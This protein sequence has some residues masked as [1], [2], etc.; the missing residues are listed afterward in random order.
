MGRI[1]FL[2]NHVCVGES[3][4]GH[5]IEFR[6]HQAD[7]KYRLFDK[8]VIYIFGDRIVV[9]NSAM[10]E[11]KES[12]DLPKKSEL[13]LSLRKYIPS[14][15]RIWKSEKMYRKIME[16]L[17][18]LNKEFG[19]V[20]DDIFI[21]HDVK[22]ANAFLKR[23]PYKNTALVYH[24]QGSIYNEWSGDTGLKSNLMRN[25][26]NEMFREIVSK[27]K[28]LCFPSRGT[29]ESLI[30][31]EPQLE[32][33]VI[34]SNRKYLYNGVY[35]PDIVKEE[36]PDWIEELDAFDGYKFITAA[37]LNTAKAVERIPQYIG[38]LK[39]L[40]VKIKWILI[41]NG[42]HAELVQSEIDKYDIGNNVIWKKGNVLHL[43]LMQL[44]SVTN[45]YILFHKYSIFDLS[46]LE[47]M[48]YGNIPILTPIGGNKEVIIDGNGLFVSDFGDVSSVISL[49]KE[50]K[51]G[52]LE[53]KNKAIKRKYFDEKVFLQRYVELCDSFNARNL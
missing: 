31:S 34:K 28:F 23:F 24:M 22:M 35:C 48:H 41:G 11:F 2:T 17:D 29:E 45:F 46:T 42:V 8:E 40:G 4:G 1:F 15:L 27:A 25:Y 7:A 36:L 32:I 21:F 43:E 14:I 9:R 49:M 19:F 5:G 10:G 30:A 13:R 33:D 52:E 18:K 26:Y 47:A 44:F 16:Y 12:K 3:G 51:I 39:R 6:L 50:N 20:N 38:E 53:E 37:N